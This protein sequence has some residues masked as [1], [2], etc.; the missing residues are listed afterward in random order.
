MRELL[1]GDLELVGLD[2]GAAQL[3][4]EV[5]AG[6]AQLAHLRLQLAPLLRVGLAEV[7]LDLKNRI[8]RRGSKLE[9]QTRVFSKV[10]SAFF[11]KRILRISFI[12][13]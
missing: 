13:P 12:C 11:L 9:S 5:P 8:E 7:V 10:L 3:E 2:G 4:L 1:V 6:V